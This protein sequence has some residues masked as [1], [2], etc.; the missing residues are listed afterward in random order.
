[1]SQLLSLLNKY[2]CS[3]SVLT[4][5]IQ[6]FLWCSIRSEYFRKS[7]CRIKARVKPNVF[8]RFSSSD[9]FKGES[10]FSW[11]NKTILE[12]SK[13]GFLKDTIDLLCLDF[14]FLSAK[15]FSL[16]CEE[17]EVTGSR[18]H[19]TL[20]LLLSLQGSPLRVEEVF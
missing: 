9:E 2:F 18:D 17:F 16:E 8:L 5:L 3:I 4:D 12:K 20:L 6:C 15:L 10:F 19:L 13:F 11:G 7:E 14:F 1:M